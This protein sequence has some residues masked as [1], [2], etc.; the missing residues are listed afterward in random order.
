MPSGQVRNVCCS[1]GVEEM[2]T[3]MMIAGEGLEWTLGF[4]S[5]PLEACARA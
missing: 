1:D 3:K 4:T 5:A 2:H